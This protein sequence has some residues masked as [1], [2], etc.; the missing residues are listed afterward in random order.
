MI[1]YIMSRKLYER[2]LIGIG[3]CILVFILG[4]FIL[5]YITKT[6]IPSVTNTLFIL[7][8][9]AF[10]FTPVLGVLLILKYLY[11]SKKKKERRERKRKNHKLYYLK[12]GEQKKEQDS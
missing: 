8:G 6:E 10:T 3:I 9:S 1:K 4:Q 7:I 5:N 12:K 11:D 2:C